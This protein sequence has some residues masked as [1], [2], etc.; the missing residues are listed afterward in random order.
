MYQSSSD[1]TVA[2]CVGVETLFIVV[3]V[4]MKLFII[5]FVIICQVLVAS[6]FK[7]LVAPLIFAASMN[8]PEI[9]MAQSSRLVGNIPTAGLIFKDELKVSAIKDPKVPGVVVYIADFDRPITEKLAND[10]FADPS[11]SSLTCS[12]TGVVTVG[13]NLPVEGEGEEIFEES[14]NLFFK[15]KL[16]QLIIYSR[17]YYLFCLLYELV[18]II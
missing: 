17:T 9:A 2:R 18:D 16:H 7:K 1:T 3:I 15:V 14:R 13:D 5:L 10:F 12:K 6:G 8:L 11:S 4:M